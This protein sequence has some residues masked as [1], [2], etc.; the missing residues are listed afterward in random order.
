MGDLEVLLMLVR[1]V[2]SD[3]MLANTLNI[4]ITV[5]M[6]IGDNTKVCVCV[7]VYVCVCVCVCMYVCM[8]E[9]VCMYVCMYTCIYIYSQKSLSR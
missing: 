3:E 6:T 2:G 8:Y 9:C 1:S 7:C 5:Y 4:L